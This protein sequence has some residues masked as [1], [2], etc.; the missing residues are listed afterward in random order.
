MKQQPRLLC[1]NSPGSLCFKISQIPGRL[2][3]YCPALFQPVLSWLDTWVALLSWL[4]LANI[5]G[6]AAFAVSGAL[7]AARNRMDIIGLVFMANL[8][9]V[10]GGTVRD[11]LLD[12]PVFWVSQWQYVGVCSIAAVV[13][14]YST[15]LI[16]KGSKALLWADALGLSL[17]CVL[18]TQKAIEAGSSLPAAV[19]MGVFSACL[20]GIFRDIALNQVPLVLRREIYVTA[21]LIGS[22]TF[23]L[24]THW[25]AMNA[26]VSG[27][28]AMSTALLI[29][30]LAFSYGITLPRH[31]GTGVQTDD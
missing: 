10:G 30:A 6:T 16:E 26:L 15:P 1:A 19:I 13:T 4:E 7:L 20:G 22:C 29:R 27:I 3:S 5:L 18:G 8:T 21:A 14:W 25:A 23:A 2:S 12:L 17:F 24:L 28:L 9:G 31:P 11:L